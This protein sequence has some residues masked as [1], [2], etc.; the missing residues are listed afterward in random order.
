MLGNHDHQP[1]TTRRVRMLRLSMNEVVV[2]REFT[3]CLATSIETW[4]AARAL[5]ME[6]QQAKTLSRVR[7][8]RLPAS[9]YPDLKNF[10]AQA[11]E[12]GRDL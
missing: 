6:G 1:K 3:A 5:T 10:L 7:R 12:I 4:I 11:Q 9:Q 8:R 2:I